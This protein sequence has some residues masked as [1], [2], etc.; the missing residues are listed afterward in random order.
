MKLWRNRGRGARAHGYQPLGISK[1]EVACGELELADDVDSKL[2]PVLPVAVD[3][4]HCIASHDAPANLAAVPREGG[5]AD[6]GECLVANLR[7]VAVN[8]R[9]VDAILVGL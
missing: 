3:L 4:H 7:A 8:R 5:V 1:H 6:I 9:Y 2:G